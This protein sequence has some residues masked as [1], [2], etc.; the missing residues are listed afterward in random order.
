MFALGWESLARESKCEQ[1]K[2]GKT[3]NETSG[4]SEGKTVR[5]GKFRRCGKS[6]G[7]AHG[8]CGN[9]QSKGSEGKSLARE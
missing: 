3:E 7:K 1:V 6:E 2:A 8:L 4:Q 9:A 5:H